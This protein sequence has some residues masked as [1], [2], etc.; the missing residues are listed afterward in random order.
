MH[1]NINDFYLFGCTNKDLTS[2]DDIKNYKLNES[3][4]VNGQE[5]NL[6]IAIEEIK[7]IIAAK[8]TIH[9]DGLIC[10]QNSQNLILNWSESLRSSINHS[11]SE[12]INNFYSAYQIYGGSL[13]S[14]NEV[15]KRSDLI[16]FVGD[17][18]DSLLEKFIKK[19]DWKNSKMS[20]EIFFLSQKKSHIIKNLINIKES[21][22][23]F[24]IFHNLFKKELKQKNLKLI[25][26][27]ISSSK[28]P[29]IIINPTNGFSFTQKLLKITEFI[30]NNIRKVR[31]FRICGSNNSS[32]FVNNCVVK[33]GFPGS[34]SFNDW[35]LSY[36][37]VKY[38]AKFQRNLK[39]IQIY[40]SNLNPEP[41]I[42]KFKE[43]IFIGHPNLK[44]KKDY[45]IYIPVKTPGID[46]QGILLRSDGVGVFKLEKKINSNY[47][48]L[49]E[50]IKELL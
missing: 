3:P 32:G 35:G 46:T 22:S 37:P 4:C 20:E 40:I 18:D 28:Y 21:Q 23:F 39:D 24:N 42:I 36:N 9:F 31:I 19:L 11:E 1:K 12:E 7:K 8:K 15:K 14:F 50:L 47:I 41:Q 26:E 49:N 13:V 17:F 38:N 43:N 34:I 29:V 16:I 30:N 45:K 10:D 33:T 2:T 44:K 6:K 25:H 27:K 5:T 48:Q